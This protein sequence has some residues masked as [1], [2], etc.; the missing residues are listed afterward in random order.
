MRTVMTAITLAAIVAVPV[1]AHAVWG[2]APDGDNHPAVGAVYFDADGDGAVS[3]FDLVCSLGYLGQSTDRR[4]D[5]VLTAGHCLPP[6]EEMIPA[7]LVLVSFDNNQ[8]DEVPDSPIRVVGWERMPGWYRNRSDLR[9]LGVF[10]LP[11]GSV[12]AAFPAAAATPVRL[13]AAGLLD[14]LDAARAL[15]FAFVD[16]VG[17]GVTPIWNVPGGLRLEYDGVRRAGSLIVTGL[18]SAYV[19]YN[20]N[21]K[22]IGT[23]SGVCYGDSGSPNLFEGGHVVISVTGGGSPNCNSVVYN[24][25]V[26]TPPARAFLGQFVEID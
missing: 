14:D 19:L 15:K 23:G 13:P 6:P 8:D 17:Y 11:A 9:D 16:V 2:G 3:V 1:T 5:V 20:Q 10:L 7:E 4:H 25:R 21:P 12:A 24:T 26:D 22:G 18:T